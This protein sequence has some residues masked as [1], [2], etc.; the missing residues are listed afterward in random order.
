MNNNKNYYQCYVYKF[1]KNY[2]KCAITV[3]EEQN[4]VLKKFT[5][6][7]HA[8]EV[9]HIDVIHALNNIKKKALQTHKKPAQ[10]IQDAAVNMPKE[11][12]S[13]MPN[14]DALYK[15][16]LYIRNKNLLS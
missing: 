10:L 15:Q 6:H 1:L 5:S 16:I 13:Y 14:N 9:F 4:H 3:L 12:F 2:K 11:S 8:Y 7:N